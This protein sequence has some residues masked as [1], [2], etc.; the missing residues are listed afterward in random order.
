MTSLVPGN[1]QLGRRPLWW[2]MHYCSGLLLA[3]FVGIH[4]LNHLLV[5][6]SPALHLAFMAAAR[7]VY[8]HPLG[9]TVLLV[10]VLFQIGTGLRLVGFCAR[11]IGDNW[12]RLQVCAGLYLALFLAIHVSSVLM[13]RLSAHL[14]TNLYFAAAGLNH[15][16]Q[17]LFFVPYYSLAILAFFGHVAAIHRLK[18]H[19]RLAAITPTGQAWILLIMGAA[20]NLRRALRYDKSF[21]GNGNSTKIPIAGT[22]RVPQAL[23]SVLARLIRAMLG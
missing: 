20:I 13:G 11:E 3:V 17:L 23:S 12:R 16:P 7:K 5:V 14:D 9:E 4:L 6:I 15:Y 1:E 22:L 19:R 2:Q 18:M 10:A 21:S 8:R